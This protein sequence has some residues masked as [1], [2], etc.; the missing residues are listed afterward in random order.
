MRRVFV[1][2]EGGEGATARIEKAGTA[3]V[4]CAHE[5]IML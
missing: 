5:P 2:V 3:E 4:V 1:L